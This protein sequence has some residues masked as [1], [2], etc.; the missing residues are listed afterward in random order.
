LKPPWKPSIPPHAMSRCVDRKD[1]SDSLSVPI[2]S[3]DKVHVGDKVVVSYYQ[4]I[5]A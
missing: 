1:P 5:A 3:L 2:K 4:G